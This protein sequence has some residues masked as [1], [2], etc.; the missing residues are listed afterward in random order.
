[1]S[2]WMA[3]WRWGDSCQ[4]LP[5]CLDRKLRDASGCLDMYTEMGQKRRTALKLGQNE[6]CKRLSAR[7]MMAI[8][9]P[10]RL[11]STS[12]SCGGFCALKP[13]SSDEGNH[14]VEGGEGWV[15]GHFL[16]WGAS[17]TADCSHRLGVRC[18]VGVT[19]RPSE[20]WLSAVSTAPRSPCADSMG[21]WHVVIANSTWELLWYQDSNPA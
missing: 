1:M 18:C 8:Q 13:R 20:F 6:T 14:R 4:L 16:C 17:S 15:W 7:L 11:C 9:T 3:Q 12:V 21:P 19:S 2:S 5:L 10:Q